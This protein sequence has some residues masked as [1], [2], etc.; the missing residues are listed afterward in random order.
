MSMK[1][2][3]EMAAKYMSESNKADLKKTMGQISNVLKSSDGQKIAETLSQTYGNTVKQ[4][5]QAAKAGDLESAKRAV[6]EILSTKEGAEMAS[7]ILSM[8]GK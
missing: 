5:A 2:Y 8:L 1:D 3:E 4:A 6:N 7:K